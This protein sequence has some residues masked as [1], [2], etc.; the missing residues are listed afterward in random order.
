MYIEQGFGPYALLFLW[1]NQM[2]KAGFSGVVVS[3]DQYTFASGNP[4]INRGK[5]RDAAFV[6]DEALFSFF[7]HPGL[8]FSI[9]F[10]E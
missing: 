5:I 7:F 9:R 3:F 8:G 4:V 2:Q 10:F 1:L 6:I